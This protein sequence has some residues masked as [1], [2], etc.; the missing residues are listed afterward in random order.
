[1]ATLRKSPTF[2]S[3]SGKKKRLVERPVDLDSF[4]SLGLPSKSRF[5]MSCTEEGKTLKSVSACHFDRDL[6]QQNGEVQSVNQQR[7]GTLLLGRSDAQIVKIVF[8]VYSRPPGKGGSPPHL[9]S[10]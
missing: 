8:K 1:M 6:Q 5:L 10:L 4:F 7:N 3:S 9:E 2:S